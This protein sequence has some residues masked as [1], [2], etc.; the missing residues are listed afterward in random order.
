MVVG[1]VVIVVEVVVVMVV[2]VLIIHQRINLCFVNEHIYR[3]AN[4]MN[5]FMR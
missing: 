5:N 4:F 3:P 2:P 1:V